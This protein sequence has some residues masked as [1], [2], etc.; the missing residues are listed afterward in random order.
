MG[1]R[2][3]FR[4]KYSE[5]T[6]VEAF[7]RNFGSNVSVEDK[8]QFFVFT[9]LN[10]ESFTFDCQVVLHGLLSERAGNYFCF[11]GQFIEALTGQFGPVEVED[12]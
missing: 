3:N 8:G 7:L 9:P 12:A 11:L 6:E 2:Q 1:L 4:F 10:G 5:S